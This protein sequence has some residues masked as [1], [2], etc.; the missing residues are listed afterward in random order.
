MGNRHGTAKGKNKYG[1]DHAATEATSADKATS[2]VNP[3]HEGAIL[4]ISCIPGMTVACSDDRLISAY[5]WIDASPPVK[6]FYFRGHTKAV[7]K[8]IVSKSAAL[9][10]R[11]RVWSASRDLSIR[12]VSK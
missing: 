10:G 11:A 7:N 5:P 12:Q 8:V 6:P 2:D 3:L 4:G 1:G 9:E